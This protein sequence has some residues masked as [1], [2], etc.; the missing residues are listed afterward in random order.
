MAEKSIMS[1]EAP[2]QII[3]GKVSV[4]LDALL[5]PRIENFKS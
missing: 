4:V 5:V 2:L 3:N 1:S